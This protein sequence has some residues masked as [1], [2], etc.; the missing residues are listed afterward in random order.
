MSDVDHIFMLYGDVYKIENLLNGK[1]YIGQTTAGVDRRMYG[2]RRQAERV[3][4]GLHEGMSKISRAIAKYGFENFSVQVIDRAETREALDAKEQFWIAAY[5]SHVQGIG[6]NI[7]MGGR[8]KGAVSEETRAKLR[9][10]R[11]EE[12]KRKVSESLKKYFKEHPLSEERKQHMRDLAS[13][14]RVRSEEEH[15]RRSESA[16][17][18]WQR[19]KATQP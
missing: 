12:L 5:S 2:H 7:E 10:P 6:Y 16:K 1:V 17:R 13:K 9:G 11:T 4:R 8:S 14:P 19:K 15:Q 3:K 18:F